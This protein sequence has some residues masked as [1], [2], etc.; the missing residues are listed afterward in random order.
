[1]EAGRLLEAVVEVADPEPNRVEAAGPPEAGKMT[2]AGKEDAQSTEDVLDAL[3][4]AQERRLRAGRPYIC[5]P[6]QC[7]SLDPSP[8]SQSYRTAKLHKKDHRR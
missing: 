1:M 3:E 5:P 2:E 8:L 4:A 6:T 7:L